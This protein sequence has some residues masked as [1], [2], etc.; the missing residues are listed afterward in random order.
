MRKKKS[1]LLSIYEYA[2]NSP[3]PH[4][5]RKEKEDGLLSIFFLHP[6]ELCPK[7]LKFYFIFLFTPVKSFKLSEKINKH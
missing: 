3:N 4:M 6:L 1:K 2:F 7:P 5:K